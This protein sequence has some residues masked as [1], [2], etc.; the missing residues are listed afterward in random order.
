MFIG[1]FAPA[2]VAATH[3]KAPSLPVLFVAAQLADW[4]FFALLIFGVEAM[5]IVPGFTVM[6]P[7][8]LYHMPYTHSLLGNAVF[9]GGVT[10]IIWTLMRAKVDGNG[11]TVVIWTGIIAGLVV[12][13][14]WFLDWLVHAPDLTLAGHPPKYGLGLWNHPAIEIPLEIGI[15]LGALWWFSRATGARTS[16]VLILG[17]TLLG[18]QVINWFG[19]MPEKVDGMISLMAF[20]AYGIATIAAW[21]AVRPM[22]AVVVNRA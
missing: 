9:G 5:R 19:P 6:T 7:F 20:A 21:W 11:S 1:H 3:K 22:E 4:A 13:S 8:D 14:H 17:A 15:T 16:G 12:L 10:V 18:L 2:L